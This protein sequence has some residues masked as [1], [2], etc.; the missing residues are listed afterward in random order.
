M[1][2]DSVLEAQFLIWVSLRT[3]GHRQGQQRQVWHK[4]TYS[5]WIHGRPSGIWQ[6]QK[7]QNVA[8][9][10]FSIFEKDIRQKSLSSSAL[11]LCSWW[12]QG[13]KPAWT[14]HH[15]WADTE[16]LGVR[17]FSGRSPSATEACLSSIMSL[18]YRYYLVSCQLVELLILQ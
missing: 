15:H 13:C 10:P 8:K 2:V 17:G 18:A 14:D 9:A 1:V 16:S 3:A 12:F 7:Q 11:L 6:H 4:P 5:L